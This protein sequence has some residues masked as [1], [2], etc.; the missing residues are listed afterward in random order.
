M[1]TSED[2]ISQQEP[3]APPPRRFTL[4]WK[5]LGLLALLAL[6][7]VGW[8]QF[9]QNLPKY[10]EW[11]TYSVLKYPRPAGD[12][13]LAAVDNCCT[14]PIPTEQLSQAERMGRAIAFALYQ[15]PH[16]FLLLSL[17]VF[18]MGVVRSYFAPERVRALLAGRLGR[19]GHPLAALLGV[20]TPF[21]SCSAVPLFVGFVTAGIPLGVTFTFLTAAP[22][23][24]EV[25]LFFLVKEFG[26]RIAAL[27]AITGLSIALF[28]GWLIGRIRGERYVEAWV[29]EAAV[30]RLAMEPSQMVME[31]RFRAGFVAWKEILG[32]VWLFLVIG[33]LIGTVVHAYVSQE[34]LLGALGNKQWWS[35]PLAVVVGVPIYSNP[36]GVLPVMQAL[37]GKGVAL[38]TVLTFLMAVIALSLPEFIILRKVLK[39]RLIALFALIVACG[40]IIVGYLFNWLITPGS[41]FIP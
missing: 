37:L 27:Y 12:P 38:G 30:H 24:N 17:V 9:D 22:L 7:I 10:A 19:F 41:W 23:V 8:Y 35:V 5:S 36:A 32:R 2:T 39:T 18:V 3:V 33:V 14:E 21:C 16:V 28:A 25:A 11:Y 29:K 34:H 26:I 20:L 4:R 15:F 40:I 6:V 13:G 31:D 1:T